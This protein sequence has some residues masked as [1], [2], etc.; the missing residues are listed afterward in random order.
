[1]DLEIHMKN[2]HEKQSLFECDQCGKGF[3]LKWRLRKHL[4]LHTQTNVQP[5]HYFNNNVKCP[6]EE[7]GCKFLHIASKNCQFCQKRKRTLCPYRHSETK[8]NSIVDNEMDDLEN[9]ERNENDTTEDNISFTTSTPQKRSE[10]NPD[11]IINMGY[12]LF[13]QY[14]IACQHIM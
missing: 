2:C 9:S 10:N 11:L 13:I 1:M 6:F 14:N 3:V 12:I 8:S 7:F 4:N 5:C